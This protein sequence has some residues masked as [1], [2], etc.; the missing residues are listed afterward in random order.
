MS[1]SLTPDSGLQ[2]MIKEFVA[3]QCFRPEHR[4][5]CSHIYFDTNKT[6]KHTKCPRSKWIPQIAVYSYNGIL[7]HMEKQ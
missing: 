4:H 3:H 2:F 5:E 7:P 1:K 6:W